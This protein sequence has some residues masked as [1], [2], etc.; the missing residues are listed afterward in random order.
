[1]GD[2]YAKI[3]CQWCGQEHRLGYS[4]KETGLPYCS[5][6]CQEKAGA[7]YATSAAKANAKAVNSKAVREAR[8]RYEEEKY[9][10]IMAAA[11]AAAARAKEQEE[12]EKKAAAAAADADAEA[13]KAAM[14][15]FY[16]TAKEDM[17]RE[18]AGKA[19]GGYSRKLRKNCK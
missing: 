13:V 18:K 12:R 19:K 15:R 14:A 8:E 6:K 1:M 11:A 2:S 5:S 4:Y 7:S 10:R 16:E 9:Q 3:D 17:L